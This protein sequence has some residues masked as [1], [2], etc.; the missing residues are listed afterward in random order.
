LPGAASVFYQNLTEEKLVE[1]RLAGIEPVNLAVDYMQEKF[2][3]Q[4]DYAARKM[5]CVT[6]SR[7]LIAQYRMKMDVDFPV[8]LCHISGAGGDFV[9]AYQLRRDEFSLF[10]IKYSD[11]GFPCSPDPGDSGQPDMLLLTEL[12]YS[13]QH[14]FSAIEPQNAVIFKSSVFHITPFRRGPFQN[15]PFILSHYRLLPAFCKAA[16]HPVEKK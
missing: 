10:R 2:S 11:F 3:G 12:F 13:F 9:G 4:S 1:S 8:H 14:F 16:V 15:G 7:D 5:A 6:F